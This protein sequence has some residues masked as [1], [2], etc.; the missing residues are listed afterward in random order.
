MITSNDADIS[1]D[2]TTFNAESDPI[3]VCSTATEI[4]ETTRKRSKREFSDQDEDYHLPEELQSKKSRNR[5]TIFGEYVGTKI[6]ALKSKYSQNVV[7][8]LIS[9]ILFDASIGKYDH[10]ENGPIS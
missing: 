5:F 8:H 1:H 9:N 4:A 7:E 3:P 2:K 10:P 6:E